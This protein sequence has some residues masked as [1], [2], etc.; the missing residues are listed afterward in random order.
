MNDE[1]VHA[2]ALRMCEEMSLIVA[3]HL[4]LAID[5]ALAEERE[6]VRA[7]EILSREEERKAVRAEHASVHRAL[8]AILERV[9]AGEA[10]ESVEKDYDLEPGVI[11]RLCLVTAL[12]DMERRIEKDE[13]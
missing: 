9:I 12:A 10:L 8:Q 4:Q 6:S 2:I 7:S 1:R 3:N 13:P 5:E 11:Q